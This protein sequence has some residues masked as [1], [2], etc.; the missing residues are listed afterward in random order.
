[1]DNLQWL[2][3]QVKELRRKG[4]E[5][6]FVILFGGRRSIYDF[7]LQVAQSHLR[8]DLAP[9]HWS[10]VAMIS[11]PTSNQLSARTRILEVSLEPFEGFQVPCMH[12]GLQA[13]PL[14]RYASPAQYPNVALIRVPVRR[15][16]WQNNHNG[17]KSI[18]AQFADQRSVL[19]VTSL[20]LEW[21]A[22]VWASGDAG[23]PLLNG[24]GI[25]S[26]AVIESLLGAAGYDMSP[27]L[28]TSASSPEAFWQTAKWWQTYY[29]NMGIEQMVTRY[30]VADELAGEGLGGSLAPAAGTA[31]NSD[32]KKATKRAESRPRGLAAARLPEPK[33]FAADSMTAA[34]FRR[35]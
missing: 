16:A 31:K 1:M 22:F 29:E 32:R 7:R 25:P 26:A 14:N 24:H 2:N 35:N 33:M 5:D 34:M 17:Q 20:M 30:V 8:A 15:A 27:G 12:N 21:L 18:L 13:A 6:T 11:T 4:T 3:K 28:D 9:S 23:N 19:D 10:H